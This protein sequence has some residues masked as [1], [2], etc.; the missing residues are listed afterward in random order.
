MYFPERRKNR[1]RMINP[2][3]L[4][5]GKSLKTYLGKIIPFHNSAD[6]IVIVL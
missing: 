1:K 4:S 6:I 5:Q 3:K 2:Y